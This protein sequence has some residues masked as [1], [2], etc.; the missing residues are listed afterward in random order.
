[1]PVFKCAWGT[2]NSDS[3]Y[4]DKPY[5]DGVKFFTFPK[6]VDGDNFHPNTINCMMWIKMCG[7]RVE[8]LNL[9]KVINDVKKRSYYYRVCSKVSRVYIY[10]PQ[11]LYYDIRIVC[12]VLS[13]LYAHVHFRQYG[14]A[15]S[16]HR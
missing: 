13:I 2:C 6:P 10:I 16:H 14:T 5:M 1:M 4:K 3:R 9:D 8:D 12:I 7:R 11:S 15:S